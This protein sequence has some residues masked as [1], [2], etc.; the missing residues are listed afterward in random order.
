V[1]ATVTEARF[2]LTTGTG[3]AQVAP[4]GGSVT[5]NIGS[6]Y[7]TGTYLIAG[8]LIVSSAAAA[9]F[10]LTFGFLTGG[11]FYGGQAGSGPSVPV[12]FTQA[13]GAGLTIP[14]CMVVD[15]NIAP[16]ALSL[17]VDNGG[18]SNGTVTPNFAL[19]KL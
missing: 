14:I 9:T 10:T 11:G 16:S 12:S 13:A 5:W 17:K 6:A 19:V 3:S 4:S 18:A 15:V 8:Y 1:Y 7:R 2:V